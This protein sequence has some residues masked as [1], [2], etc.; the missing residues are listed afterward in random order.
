M[1][2]NKDYKQIV[3]DGICI[4]YTAE[5]KNLSTYWL[6]SRIIQNEYDMHNT[7]IRETDSSAKN[8]GKI[9]TQQKIS[10]C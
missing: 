6:A 8:A 10:I 5:Y 2:N 1:S 3:C 4:H 7:M 9:N